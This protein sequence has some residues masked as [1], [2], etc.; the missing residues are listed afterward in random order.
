MN[1][2]IEDIDA[3]QVAWCIERFA[4][5]VRETPGVW[6][7]TVK[8]VRYEKTRIDLH[9]IVHADLSEG[10]PNEAVQKGWEVF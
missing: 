10:D 2:Q 1:Y 7:A 5:W 9:L 4:E 6:A 8:T 3:D